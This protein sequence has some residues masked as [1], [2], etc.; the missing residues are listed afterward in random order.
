VEVPWADLGIAH[1]CGWITFLEGVRWRGDK[2][3]R[4]ERREREQ[5]TPNEVV[6]PLQ[7]IAATIAGKRRDPRERAVRRMVIEEEGKVP[8]LSVYRH[9]D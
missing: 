4:R 8:S 1:L 3:E 7:L 2:R 9:Q 5:R 6:V